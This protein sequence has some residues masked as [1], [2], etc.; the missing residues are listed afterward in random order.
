MPPKIEVTAEA[1]AAAKADLEKM[2]EQALDE[3]S[4]FF[5]ENKK[6]IQSLIDKG[7]KRQAICDA[8]VKHGIKITPATLRKYIG[9]R[10]NAPRKGKERIDT[11]ESAK[12]E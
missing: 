8:L 3:L 7:W 1:L 10:K 12:T 2:S 5:N 4:A 9:G 6:L 11:P